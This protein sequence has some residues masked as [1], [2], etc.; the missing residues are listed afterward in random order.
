MMVSDYVST[1]V[2]VGAFAFASIAL[3]VGSTANLRQRTNN[4]RWGWLL[5]PIATVLWAVGLVSGFV[6]LSYLTLAPHEMSH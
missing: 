2:F 5:V 4:R 6:A 1:A 3:A